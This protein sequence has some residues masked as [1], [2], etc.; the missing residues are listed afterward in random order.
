[1]SNN[2]QTQE[3]LNYSTFDLANRHL[4]N[5]RTFSIF[6]LF[7]PIPLIAGA[8]KGFYFFQPTWY[9]DP[10]LW[11]ILV[12][13]STG[14]VAAFYQMIILNRGTRNA[15]KVFDVVRQG[16][17]KPDLDLLMENILNHSPSCHIRDSIVRW[18]QLGI[19]G[20]TEGLERMMEHAGM[21]RD[22]TANKIMSF[23][24]IINRTTLKMGFLGTLIGLLMTFEPMKQ[25]MLSLQGSDGEFKFINDI[26][27]A[28]DGDAYAILTTLFATGLSIFIELFTFQLFE[29]ILG[30]F[31]MVNNNLD[32][33]CLIHLQPWI[34]E[35]YAE[36][37]KL[38]NTAAMQMR[39]AEHIA[40]FQR[41]MDE[42]LRT[43]TGFVQETGRQIMTLLPFQQELA[44]KIGQ[45]AEYEK[46]YRQ[47]LHVKMQSIVPP[48]PGRTNNE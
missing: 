43:L 32:D 24:N 45:L 7:L 26:V 44:A 5:C 31:E 36:K 30:Q 40:Q 23:H 48:L 12:L 13:F 8:V 14:Q 34:K 22:Q 29:R 19:Q 4:K 17:D 47:F 41:A 16:G 38:E 42:Q 3:L 46:Q 18:M 9:T 1:M 2:K 37:S 28:L 6:F 27:K 39:F 33:W 25:A 10:F 11:V 20:E 15:R 21:R 35:N